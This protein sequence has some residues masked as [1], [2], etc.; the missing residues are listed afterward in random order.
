MSCR[1]FLVLATVTERLGRC[2]EELSGGVDEMKTAVND[3]WT[4]AVC[5]GKSNMSC[6]GT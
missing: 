3:E 1:Y 4:S 2:R 6:E 5:D